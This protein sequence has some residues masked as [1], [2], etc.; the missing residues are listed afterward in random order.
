VG[1]KVITPPI[2]T[3]MSIVGIDALKAHMQEAIDVSDEDALI[4]SYLN[5][6][7]KLA[8]A[9]TWRQFLS[10]QFRYTLTDFTAQ[11]H[12]TAYSSLRSRHGRRIASILIPKP[13][14]VSVQSVQYL[15]PNGDLFT[16]VA[17]EDYVV[18]LESDIASIWPAYGKCWPYVRPNHPAAVTI[19]YTAGYGTTLAAMPDVL[20]HAIR[21]QVGSWWKN[22][23]STD[24]R[25]HHE[26]PNAAKALLE[27]IEVRDDRLVTE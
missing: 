16:L 9:H 4:E 21:L 18:D 26:L 27:V 6:A 1:L 12:H 17:N 19:T 23:E 20:L 11:S 7:W 5:A 8:E 3:P 13:P 15:D 10:A 14:C 2:V 22:R 25:Q 24:P